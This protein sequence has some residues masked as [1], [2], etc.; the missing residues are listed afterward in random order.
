MVY[1]FAD[2]F[3]IGSKYPTLIFDSTRCSRLAGTVRCVDASG[4][5]L[6]GTVRCVDARRRSYGRQCHTSANVASVCRHNAVVITF[7]L[8]E[9]KSGGS[10]GFQCDWPSTPT[11]WPYHGCGG[12]GGGGRGD[13]RVPWGGGAGGGGGLSAKGP[14]PTICNTGSASD[15]WQATDD[16]QS[17]RNGNSRCVPHPGVIKSSNPAKNY[18]LVTHDVTS[19]EKHASQTHTNSYATLHSSFV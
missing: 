11:A 1:N 4:G 15:G 2:I 9:L 16:D 14:S 12:G 6:T 5:R 17:S 7:F 19:T 8:S 10:Q 18:S 13:R 3:S